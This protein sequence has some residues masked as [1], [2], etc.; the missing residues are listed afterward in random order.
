M[1]VGA[2]THLYVVDAA[3]RGN[4]FVIGLRGQAPS[5]VFNGSESQWVAGNTA[6]RYKPP[7]S[8]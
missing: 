5:E 8:N 2:T 1:N 6:L 3:P 4:S 7:P